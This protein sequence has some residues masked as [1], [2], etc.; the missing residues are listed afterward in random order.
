MKNHEPILA[1][2]VPCHW[3]F[4]RSIFFL[5]RLARHS[6][7]YSPKSRSAWFLELF[8]KSGGIPLYGA[9]AFL[10]TSSKFRLCVSSPRGDPAAWARARLHYGGKL[11]KLGV[12]EALINWLRADELFIPRNIS[13]VSRV[14]YTIFVWIRRGRVLL[15]LPGLFTC[16]ESEWLIKL[17]ILSSGRGDE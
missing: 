1:L 11:Q 15:N 10:V 14:H 16:L 2:S 5:S 9:P 3:N 13:V 4:P 6:H 12:V 8:R 7:K 17:W